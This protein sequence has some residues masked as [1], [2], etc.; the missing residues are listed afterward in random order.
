MGRWRYHRF[1]AGCIDMGQFG[2]SWDIS[3][4]HNEGKIITAHNA[5]CDAYENRIA[6]LEEERDAAVE[7]AHTV[8]REFAAANATLERLRE[9]VQSDEWIYAK[10]TDDGQMERI[11]DILYPQPQPPETTP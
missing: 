2:I 11:E 1:F 5:D 3:E 9:V 4:E 6:D 7:F 10:H 8:E